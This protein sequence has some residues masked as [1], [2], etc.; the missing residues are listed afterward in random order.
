MI[1][2]QF[3]NTIYYL[4][5]DNSTASLEHATRPELVYELIVRLLSGLIYTVELLFYIVVTHE[6]I[7]FLLGKICTYLGIIRIPDSYLRMGIL[8]FFIWREYSC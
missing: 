5:Y 8:C 4:L 6:M 3:N 7:S 1:L 2:S